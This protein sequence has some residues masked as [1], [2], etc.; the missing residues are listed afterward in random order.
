MAPTTFSK[1]RACWYTLPSAEGLARVSHAPL[2]KEIATIE[3]SATQRARGNF[4]ATGSR[5]LRAGLPDAIS[6]EGVVVRW[7][8]PLKL[9]AKGGPPGRFSD[10]QDSVGRRPGWNPATS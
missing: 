3:V 9:A 1:R 8:G 10:P 6:G 5:R 2:R 4:I 7:S